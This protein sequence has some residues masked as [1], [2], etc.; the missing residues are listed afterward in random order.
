MS[1]PLEHLRPEIRALSPYTISH[2]EARIKLDANENPFG[3][4]EKIRREIREVLDRI[5]VNRYPDPAATE[6]KAVIAKFLRIPA[7]RLL[8]GNGSDELIGY[9]ITT[10]AG[11]GNG[12]LYPAPTFSMYGIIA[13]AFG[14]KRIEVPLDAH[15]KIDP[16]RLTSTIH[17]ASPEIIFLASPN[18][19]TGREFPE[20]VILS[21]L[22]ESGAVVVLDEAYIDFSGHAG[23][24]PL[25]DRYPNLIIL[26]TL[27]KI[28]M[29][30][31]RLGI[32]TAAPEILREIEKVRLPYNVNTFSQA[33]ATVLLGHEESL[34]TQIE[35]IV[36]ERA[37]LFSALSQ[38]P[39]ITPIPSTA[40]FI[41]FRTDEA[42]RLFNSLL[43]A[44]IL[45]RNLN[46]PGPLAGSLRVTIGTPEENH[47]FICHLQ[48]FFQ[49][50]KS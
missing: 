36:S 40:N 12:V 27:S 1:H 44:G 35:T 9:L 11:K 39:Q 49:G 28:G 2:T 24:L 31:L 19:P 13:A 14:Q 38:I 8:L 26:R 37:R 20:E 29:A 22:E 3:P 47:E 46:I 18:N 34:R 30:S 4:S 45:I 5:A 41:L 16:D 42:D 6:L 17:E 48:N 21:L 23:S 7:D 43:N 50:E 15:F 25:L 10:F 32:L 33:A